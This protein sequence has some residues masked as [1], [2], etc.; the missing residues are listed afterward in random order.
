MNNNNTDHNPE[1]TALN[2]RLDKLEQEI[3][4]TREMLEIIQEHIE[5]MR[6]DGPT[7]L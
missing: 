7:H 1:M 3:E 4:W 5:D 6:N 2:A